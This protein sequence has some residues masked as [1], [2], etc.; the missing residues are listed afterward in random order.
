MFSEK[1]IRSLSD[2]QEMSHITW[3]PKVHYRVHSS[4]PCTLTWS[5]L[6]QSTPCQPV[7]RNNLMFSH[8]GLFVAIRPHL[9]GFPTQTLYTSPFP[10]K[11]TS[12]L[13][14]SLTWSSRIIFGETNNHE[15]LYYPSFEI[16]RHFLPLRPRCLLQCPTLGILVLHSSFHVRDQV[17]HPHK[18]RT[19]LKFSTPYSVLSYKTKVSGLDGSRHFLK[20]S[21]F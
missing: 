11:V 20:F 14:S 6:M 21:Q 18:Q 16:S 9:S 7:F 19:K 10:K 4:P 17:S 12:T 2:S 15:K 1:I 3:N 8:L 5:K 13:A